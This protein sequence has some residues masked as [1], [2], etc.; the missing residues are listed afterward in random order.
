MKRRGKMSTGYDS[1]SLTKKR[2]GSGVANPG[3]TVAISVFLDWSDRYIQKITF[4]HC[5]AYPERSYTFC[6]WM[7]IIQVLCIRYLVCGP[8]NQWKIC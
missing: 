2:K 6:F 5:A 7:F 3:I 8:E 1:A 4:I